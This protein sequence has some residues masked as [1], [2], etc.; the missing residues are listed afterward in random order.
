MFCSNCG[1]KIDDGAK[2]CDNCGSPVRMIP[3]AQTQ[4]SQIQVPP[5][6]VQQTTTK[7]HYQNTQSPPMQMPTPTTTTAVPQQIQPQTDQIIEQTQTAYVKKLPVVMIVVLTVGM[8]LTSFFVGAGSMTLATLVASVPGLILLFKIYKLDSIEPEP[9][10]L[11]VKLFLVGG[12]VVPIPVMIVEGIISSVIG[13]IF[14]AGS[15][16][17]CIASAFVVAAFTEEAFKYAGLRLLTWKNPAFNYRFDGIVYSTTLAIGF[18]IVENIL[19][20]LGDTVGTAFLRAAFP[21]H[22]IFG[23]YMGYYYGQAKSLELA[24]DIE[25]SKKMRIKGVTRAIII[26]GIYDSVCMLGSASSSF[27]LVAISVLCLLVLMCVLNVNAYKN[28]KKFAHEDKPV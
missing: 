8:F 15:V 10:P 2:F 7:I 21:G 5:P 25:G 11:L 4:N 26:H 1:N 27:V 28:I 17:Y 19:Y 22:C 9:I 16:L 13:I 6:T 12:F 23:I 3:K 14:P 20:I 18:D 24:G